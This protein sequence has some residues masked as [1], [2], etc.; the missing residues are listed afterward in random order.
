MKEKRYKEIIINLIEYLYE[1]IGDDEEA[2]NTLVN[3]VGMTETELDQIVN[4]TED[5]TDEEDCGVSAERALQMFSDYVNCDAEDAEPDYIRDTLIS[6]CGCSTEEIEAAGL[7][8]LFPD[9]IDSYLKDNGG[10]E[11][12]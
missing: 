6:V 12:E 8:W 7:T 11:E 9:G 5:P 10:E 2:Y 3:C 4:G 1:E